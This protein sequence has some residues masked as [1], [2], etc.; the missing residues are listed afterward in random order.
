LRLT[1]GAV[2]RHVIASFLYPLR[3]DG[4][5][6]RWVGGLLL[7]AVLPLSFPVVFGYAV[8]CIRSAACDPAAPPPG[9][10]LSGRLLGDGVLSAAQTAALTV[11]F[12]LIAWLLAGALAA[13]WHPFGDPLLDPALSW[14]GVLTLV[15]LPWGVVML[16]VLPPTLARFAVTGRAGDLASPRLVVACVRDR[17][18]DWNFVLV[19]I[20]TA[21]ALAV[22]GLAVLGVGVVAGAFYAILVSAHACSALAP[23]RTTG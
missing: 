20:T 19:A 12:A 14:I 10:R 9:W 23:D 16:V 4:W 15:A 1:G 13:V 11:P 3:R 2:D 5:L 18:A 8:A 6:P 21:W 7:V 17:Y 22:V